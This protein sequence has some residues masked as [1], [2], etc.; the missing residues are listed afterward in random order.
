M[1]VV[2]EPKPAFEH[3]QLTYGIELEA[4]LAFH[5]EELTSKLEPNTKVVEVPYHTREVMP[6][7]QPFINKNLKPRV[8]RS[9]GLQTGNQCPRPYGNEPLKIAHSKLAKPGFEVQIMG[10]M[11]KESNTADKYE[12]WFITK[13]HTVRGVGSK[14]I[15]GKLPHITQ[16]ESKDWDSFG[17][18]VVSRVLTTGDESYK[19]EIRHVVQSLKGSDNDTHGAFVT[20][21]C[22]LHVHVQADAYESDGWLGE[23]ANILMVY[24]QELSRLH[25]RHCRPEHPSAKG[26]KESN[27][28]R[29]LLF[30]DASMDETRDV[31]CSTQALINKGASKSIPRIRK[32][33]I[34]K[35]RR[36]RQDL[37]EF[38]NFPT[39][40]RNENIRDR[41]VN[42]VPA[43]RPDYNGQKLPKTVEFRQHCGTLCENDIN[44][45]V[46]FVTGLVRLAHYYDQ[47]PERFPVRD[48]DDP[49]GISVFDLLRDMDAT[50]DTVRYWQDRI[51]RNA[52]EDQDSDDWEL[53]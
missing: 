18:E 33:L 4:I 48:W 27:R 49:T 10:D 39:N 26:V 7:T 15:S 28:L 6:F 34:S 21:Q 40:Q 3:T 8:Y 52:T 45:W 20:K 37:I 50:E 53:H 11:Q 23:L 43:D 51:C 22:A 24:E 41:L 1:V 16:E 42:F 29:L 32:Q 36:N 30:P 47:N 14:N 2:S 13:D 46:D 5:R 35:A 38:M 31:D 19:D 17:I 9:W 25:P 44:K 12:K